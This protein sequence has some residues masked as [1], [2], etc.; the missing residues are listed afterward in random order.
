[1]ANF[2]PAAITLIANIRKANDYVIFV[3]MGLKSSLFKTK[4]RKYYKSNI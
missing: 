3:C 4:Q 2:I 1:M